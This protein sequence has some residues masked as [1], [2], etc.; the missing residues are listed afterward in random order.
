MSAGICPEKI[1]NET[2][3]LFLTKN[4]DTDLVGQIK[5]TM[6]GPLCTGTYFYKLGM[7]KQTFMS[8]S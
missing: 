6:H 4:S 7:Q 3:I 2:V 8:F 1:E 5:Q